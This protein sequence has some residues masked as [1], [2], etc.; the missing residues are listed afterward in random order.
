MAPAPKQRL[1]WLAKDFGSRA[2]IKADRLSEALLQRQ[3]AGQ[4]LH[5][6]LWLLHFPTCRALAD[7]R[8]AVKKVAR[9]NFELPVL[10]VFRTRAREHDLVFLVSETP[11]H[12]HVQALFKNL[13]TVL[14]NETPCAH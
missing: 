7:A 11:F 6:E 14:G 9:S 2:F 8:A 13:G 4:P 12:P 3:M 10:T 5:L 1:A